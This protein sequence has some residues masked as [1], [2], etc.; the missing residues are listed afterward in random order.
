MVRKSVFTKQQSQEQVN[1]DDEGEDDLNIADD[2]TQP[3]A[4]EQVVAEEDNEDEDDDVADLKD[5]RMLDD[6]IDVTQYEKHMMHLWNSFIRKQWVLADAHASW[7]CEAYSDIHEEELVL[8][9]KL[10]CVL[11]WPSGRHDKL[12]S[13]DEQSNF[14]WSLDSSKKSAQVQS[15]ESTGILHHLLGGAW[16]PHDV[17]VVA[18]TF[19]SSIQFWDLRTMK[20]L[21]KGTNEFIVA[22]KDSHGS[23]N[24]TSML[25]ALTGKQMTLE[26]SH[27][28][29]YGL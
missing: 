28:C 9:P 6:F 19:E 3:M 21:N 16:D 11:W 24:N 20:H 12:I 7:A 2:V 10:N 26:L 15:Q 5:Q 23:S 13:I 4:L 22:T 25:L 1:P 27:V 14:L 29:T 17:N 8:K 18:S